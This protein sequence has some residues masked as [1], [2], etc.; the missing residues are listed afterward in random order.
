MT[1]YGEYQDWKQLA[2]RYRRVI[3]SYGTRGDPKE[4]MTEAELAVFGYFGDPGLPHCYAGVYFI[5]S[6]PYIKI[7]EARDPYERMEPFHTGNPHG[8]ELLHVIAVDSKKE[9]RQRE[10]ELHRSFNHLLLPRQ[11]EWFQGH[12]ELTGFIAS[13]CARECYP[14]PT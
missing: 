12:P 13:S 6:G 2:G 1:T 3:N 10:N 7:G 14:S 8:L 9:R 5:A 4:A 11:R